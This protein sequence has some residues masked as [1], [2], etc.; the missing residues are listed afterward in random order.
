[1]DFEHYRGV[2]VGG[3][4]SIRN[5]Q[6]YSATQWFNGL[7]IGLLAVTIII[8][9]FRANRSNGSSSS[10]AVASAPVHPSD[11][12]PGN[13]VPLKTVQPFKKISDYMFSPWDPLNNAEKIEFHDADNMPRTDYILPGGSRLVTYGY[14]NHGKSNRPGFPTHGTYD[15]KS[16]ATERP[17]QAQTTKKNLNVHSSLWHNQH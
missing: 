6:I 5:P 10:K 15:G 7:V 17:I 1:M 4:L 3:G 14:V 13:T 2:D 16:L 8:I 9:I 12:P 11:H